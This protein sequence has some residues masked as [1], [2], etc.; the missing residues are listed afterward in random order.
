MDNF[1]KLYYGEIN[2]YFV[3]LDGIFDGLVEFDKEGFIYDFVWSF[4]FCEFIVCY[5]YMFVWM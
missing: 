3:G 4:I 2:F 5:G 1:G